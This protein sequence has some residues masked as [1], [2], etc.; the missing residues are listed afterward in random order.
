GPSGWSSPN[1]C[2]TTVAAGRGPGDR[3]AC[4]AP[5]RYRPSIERASRVE[6]GGERRENQPPEGPCG[7]GQAGPG[8]HESRPSWNHAGLSRDGALS[9]YERV[10]Q[11]LPCGNR[12]ARESW[13][14]AG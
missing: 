7:A 2:A 13:A 1:R 5:G 4:V 10:R 9:A 3:V 6:G 8:G 14:I 12:P 11:A